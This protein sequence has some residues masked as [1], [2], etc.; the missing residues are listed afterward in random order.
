VYRHVSDQAVTDDGR[1]YRHQTVI[2]IP[3]LVTAQEPLAAQLEHFVGL[4]AGSVDAD[5]ERASIIPSHRVIDA[6]KNQQ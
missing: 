6:L 5:A 2:E 1:G 3:E 4:I